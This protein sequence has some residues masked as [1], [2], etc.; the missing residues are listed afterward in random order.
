[1]KWLIAFVTCA[2][3]GALQAAPGAKL[4][5]PSSKWRVDYAKDMCVLLRTFGEG[6]D[7]VTVGFKPAPMSDQLEL[8]V[9]K[10]AGGNARPAVG[11][12]SIGFG[13]A[14]PPIQASFMSTI[15]KGVALVR[16]DL[17][18]RQLEPLKANAPLGIS[19]RNRVNIVVDPQQFATA[20]EAV[21]KC[22]RDLLRT[23]GMD[24]ATLAAVTTRPK[25]I[26]SFEAHDYPDDALRL[27]HV[28]INSARVAIGA[29]GSVT[30]CKIVEPSGV[31]SLD[32]QTCVGLVKRGYA[33]A[34]DANG[35]ALPSVTFVR[36][37]WLIEGASGYDYVDASPP[38]PIP[39]P[40]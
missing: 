6:S 30:E 33:P 27:G 1:M 2:M 19:V 7:K 34:R 31:P 36:V 32:K 8:M 11:K 22:E 28:G 23:W 18:R 9:V 4:L 3:A 24:E 16:M 38:A 10:P 14:A 20:M 5:A 17:S 25:P 26:R 29:D 39:S 15:A 35:K 21:G 37:T 40:N 12:A 13:T